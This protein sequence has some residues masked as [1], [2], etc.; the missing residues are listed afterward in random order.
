[1]HLP[2]IILHSSAIRFVISKEDSKHLMMNILAAV[3][4]DQTDP[5]FSLAVI[6]Y[7]IKSSDYKKKTSCLFTNEIFREAVRELV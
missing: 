6:M 7:E 1:M 5:Y 2:S 3:Y 4:F